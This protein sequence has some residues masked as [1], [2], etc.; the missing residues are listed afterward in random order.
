LLLKQQ[1]AFSAVLSRPVVVFEPRHSS[2][3][4]GARIVRAQVLKESPVNRATFSPPRLQSLRSV[5][6]EHVDQGQMPGLVALVSRHDDVHVFELGSLS[7]GSPRPMRR[8]SLFRI[9]SLTKLVTAVAAMMLVEECRVRLDDPVEQWLPELANRRVL[10]S[11]DSDLDDT[12]PA[13]R[14]ITARDLFT[15]CMGFG[16]VMA[17]PGT[18]AIQQAIR[19][20]QIGGDG[21]P[22]P[23]RLPGMD[24]WLKRLGSLPL[25][26]QPGERWMYHTSSDV[27]GALIARVSGQTL[28][29]FMR[30]RIFDPLGMKDTGFALLPGRD[31]RLPVAYLPRAD[32]IG[33]DIYD[34][35]ADS[36]WRHPAMELGSGGLLSTLD[37][38]HRFLSMMLGNGRLGSVEVLSRSSIELMTQDH[39]RPSQ[40]QGAEPFFGDHSSWGLGFS[41]GVRRSQLYQ[42]PGRFGWDGGLGLSAYVDPAESLVGILF[43]QRLVTSPEPPKVYTDFWTGAYAALA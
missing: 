4:Q 36:T 18:H 37:D 3:L 34:E 8:D 26:A 28:G 17:A 23:S 19:E 11:L 41:V 27:L 31:D 13:H 30:E 20:L 1:A 7:F 40:R 21:P 38:Y 10:K 16:S 6:S 25:L 12:V 32:G 15:S 29:Q 14:A 9:A 2:C 24:E 33:F 43:T 22:L 5:L 35:A 39:L 42:R